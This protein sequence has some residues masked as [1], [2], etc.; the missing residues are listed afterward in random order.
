VA[1][2]PVPRYRISATTTHDEQRRFENALQLGAQDLV[3]VRQHV[4]MEIGR[5]EAEIF[6]AHLA[7]LRDP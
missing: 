3:R 4:E 2:A 6:D 5:A 7:L 1:Q